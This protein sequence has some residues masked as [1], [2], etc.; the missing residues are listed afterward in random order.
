MRTDE[1]AI[2]VINDTHVPELPDHESGKTIERANAA[3]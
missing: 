3:N 2:T 1:I